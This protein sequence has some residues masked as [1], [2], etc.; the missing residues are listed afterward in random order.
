[1]R[2]NALVL[3]SLVTRTLESVGVQLQQAA[4]R[5]AMV[6][7]TALAE[8]RR[9]RDEVEAYLRAALEPRPERPAT[10]VG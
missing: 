7:A 6:A 2:K 9:E 3:G 4:C 8:L 1:M 5:N 10:G